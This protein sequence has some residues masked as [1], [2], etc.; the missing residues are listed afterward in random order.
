MKKYLA[1]VN[2]GSLEKALDLF[3]IFLKKADSSSVSENFGAWIN[4]LITKGV[5]HNKQSII[6]KS[7]E[8]LSCVM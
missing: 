7:L 3:I 6:D 4:C 1:D 5:A 8:G 2:P